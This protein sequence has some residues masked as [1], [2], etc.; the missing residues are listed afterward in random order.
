MLESEEYGL[1]IGT[2]NLHVDHTVVLL[3]LAGKLVFLDAAFHIVLRVGAKHIAVLGAA[4]HS[5]RIN[6]VARLLVPYK[7]TPLLP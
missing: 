7:P 1:D 3:V 4:A 5:L 6:I 2:L